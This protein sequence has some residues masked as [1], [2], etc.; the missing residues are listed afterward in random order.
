MPKPAKPGQEMGTSSGDVL[1]DGMRK[2]FVDRFRRHQTL[3]S[4]PMDRQRWTGQNPLFIGGR[5]AR[6]L[7]EKRVAIFISLL[8][9]GCVQSPGSAVFRS[10][11]IGQTA[12][13][14]D[15]G[16]PDSGIH[17]PG[18][19]DASSLM[20]T[21]LDASHDSEAMNP[22]TAPGP[23]P[24]LFDCRSADVSIPRSSPVPINCLR[25]SDCNE[26]M[27]IGH[28]GVGGD[29]GTIAPENS[30]SAIRAALVLGLDGVEL[31]VRLTRDDELV[32]MHDRDIGRTTNGTGLVSE[33]RR[34]VLTSF[35]LSAPRL[36]NRT[37]D[38]SCERVPTLEAALRLIHGQLLVFLDVH[39][40]RV[41]L[42]ASLIDELELYE[43]VYLMVHE[44]GLISMIRAL[45]SRLQTVFPV[46]NQED[47]DRLL[48]AGPSA[49]PEVM[50]IPSPDAVLMSERLH[51]AGL[52]AMVD[53]VGTDVIASITR[54]LQGYV[55]TFQNGVD[56]IQSEYPQLVLESLE[57]WSP[58]N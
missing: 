48:S 53:T 9:I 33:M 50:I 54:D 22:I 4:R 46:G 30:L 45:D 35:E 27:V 25:T 49:A 47:L 24:E 16:L 2:A 7:N 14:V 26:P 5:S 10:M 19:R 13:G 43:T 44:E 40:E 17:I 55:D 39:T 11:D 3:R 37:G 21:G 23:A 34:G 57:R 56:L 41:D 20:D 29:F 8:M 51:Q 52:K 6:P 32:L 36:A 58:A 31:D 1:V 12:D 42:V 15:M 38:F 28:R 18:P